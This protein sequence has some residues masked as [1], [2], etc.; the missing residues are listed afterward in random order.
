M[1]LLLSGLAP[2]QSPDTARRSSL[3]DTLTLK[4]AVV[5]GTSA[6]ARLREIQAGVE[7]IRIDDMARMPALLGERDIVRS[8]QLLPGVKAAS[9]GSSGFQVRGGTSAQNLI[10]LDDA[11][12][13]NA[14]HLMG[15]FST[16]NDDALASATL[17]KGLVPASHGGATSSVFEIGT[18]PGNMEEYHCGG[19]IGL[20]SAKA[21]AEGPIARDRA[22]FFLSGRRTYFDL[23]LKLTEDYRN[24]ILNFGDLNA[25]VDWRLSDKD[26]MFLAVFRSRDKIALDELGR[27]VWTSNAGTLRWSRVYSAALRHDLSFYHGSYDSANKVDILN[28]ALDYSSFLRQTGMKL[29]WT[30]QTGGKSVLDF[31]LQ[32]AYVHVKTGDWVYNNYPEKEI[33]NALDV[34]GWVSGD[35]EPAP[36]LRFSAGLRLDAFSALG[37][38]PYYEVDGSGN[39]T[40]TLDDGP[41]K[42]VKTWWTLEPR[43]GVSL[44]PGGGRQ[45][46]KFGWTRSSQNIHALRN[47]GLSFPF[48]RNMLSSNMIRPET[49]DQV[50]LGWLVVAPDAAYDFSVEGYC[51]SMEGVLDYREGKWLGSEIEMETLVEAGAGRAYGVECN[52]RK[53]SGRLTGWI[54]YTLSWSRNR[55]EGINGGRWY[56]AANDRRHD[57][58][59]VA[60]YDFGRGWQAAVTWK[61]NTGQALSAP[62]AKYEIDGVTWYHYAEKNGYRAPDN[63]RLDLSLTCS[64]RKGRC[65]RQWVLGVYNAYD[66]RNPYLITFRNDEKSPTGTRTEQ[67]S[68]FGIVPS[69]SF[70]LEF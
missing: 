35:W 65:E 13:W 61:Y 17:Y 43:I 12:I 31:G 19:S 7:R 38:E 29:K 36:W 64:R 57:I 20:L 39:I 4:G 30:W 18:R 5:T 46:V 8:L 28:Q 22:S 60:M 67:I 41:G 26:R 10:L 49:S 54:A 63:H 2:A 40:R 45:S 69:V 55:I 32:P 52:V 24:T 58:S 66:R 16:F 14:G 11:P 6:R 50:S 48:D 68:L 70:N 37:G 9:E 1:F 44:R 62:S 25:R 34:S 3:A 42:I 33:R 47:D 27:M 53:N 51:K 59:L 23:F 15:L 21:N 56:D